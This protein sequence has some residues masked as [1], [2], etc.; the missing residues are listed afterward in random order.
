MNLEY[1]FTMNLPGRPPIQARAFTLDEYRELIEARV[2]GDNKQIR[3]ITTRLVAD[4]TSAR[5]VNRQE[6]EWI[7]VNLWAHSL[8]EVNH[9]HIWNCTCGKETLIDM[10]FS[11]AQI[12]D[13]SNE[14]WYGKSNFK[15]KLRYP[16]IF[17]DSDYGAMIASCIEYIVANDEQIDIEDLND[18]ELND[19]FSSISIQDMQ[20]IIEILMAPKLVLAV[21]VTCECGIHAVHTITGIKEFLELL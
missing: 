19:L 14:L 13:E 2:A 21:P 3:D 9:T 10:N 6:C 4:C 11:H 8:G 15:L 20:N 18:V 16:K 17:E 7:I 1:K 5:M 12:I